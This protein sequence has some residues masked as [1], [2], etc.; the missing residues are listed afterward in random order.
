[1]ELVPRS[2]ESLTGEAEFVQKNIKGIDT[3]NIPDLLKFPI[4]SW[5]ACGAV[6]NTQ[7]R[8]IPHIRAMDYD[9]NREFPHADYFIKNNMNEMLVIQG[10][11]F[12]ESDKPIFHTSSLDLIKKIKNEMKDIKIY[13]ALDPYRCEIKKEMDYMKAKIDA[14]VQGFFSQP[15][16]DLRLLEIYAETLQGFSVFWGISPVLTQKSR[17]YWESRNRAYFPR[18]FEPSL[19]WNIDFAKKAIRFC[20]DHNFN[21]YMM[22]IRVDLK[23]YLLKVF[24]KEDIN[25]L[26]GKRHLS[27][28]LGEKGNRDRG[29]GNA[30]LNGRA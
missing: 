28:R 24:E 9:N 10:D 19:E 20:K 22:P 29:K 6:S 26:Q 23:Q 8:T 1:L 2:Y 21:L 5:E 12:P 3:L 30:W 27:R 17:E 4:R 7:L 15:F 25:G 14:G 13:A 16:F 11:F 18:S